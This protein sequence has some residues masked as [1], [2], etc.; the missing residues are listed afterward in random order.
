MVCGKL[1]FNA[2]NNAPATLYEKIKNKD[3]A[4]PEEVKL[5]AMC[6]D[7]IFSCLKKDPEERISFTDLF[8]HPFSAYD[9]KIEYLRFMEN[10]Q[11]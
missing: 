10:G 7:V 6:M 11:S 4:F 2:A 3:F 8:K 1:P 9:P 5:S